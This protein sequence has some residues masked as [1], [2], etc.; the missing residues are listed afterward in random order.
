MMNRLIG[1]LTVIS[2]AFAVVVYRSYRQKLRISA[3]LSLR[4]TEKTRA[5]QE[6]TDSLLKLSY[7]RDTLIKKNSKV[8]SDFLYRVKGLCLVGLSE[9]PDPV[10][11]SYILKIDSLIQEF[12]D[13]AVAK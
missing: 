4:M 13:D 9:T 5:F 1:L 12:T 10:G 8:F 11:R 7:E 2:V 3:L 6:N